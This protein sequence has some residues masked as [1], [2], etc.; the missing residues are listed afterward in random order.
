MFA[1][2]FKMKD[3]SAEGFYE[4][5]ILKDKQGK[6][7]EARELIIKAYNLYENADT[8]LELTQKIFYRYNQY[9]NQLP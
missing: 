7:D 3:E 2:F 6:S 9:Q 4:F 1:E 5:S 8:E